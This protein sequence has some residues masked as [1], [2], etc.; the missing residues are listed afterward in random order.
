[1]TQG[2][3]LRDVGPR[4]E[5]PVSGPGDDQPS[6]PFRLVNQLDRLTD[7]LQRSTIQG[8][9]LFG[10]IDRQRGDRLAEVEPQAAK[11][12]HRGYRGREDDRQPSPFAGRRVRL[13]L[14][15]NA[16]GSPWSGPSGTTVS[17]VIRR[18][19]PRASSR[20]ISNSIPSSS[21][22]MRVRP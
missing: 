11:G 18:M 7:L 10:S 1:R 8:V 13:R 14:I 4:R 5:S 6:Y 17:T 9:Q 2:G 16:T 22:R 20:L 21:D 12:R 3:K 15:V 19:T